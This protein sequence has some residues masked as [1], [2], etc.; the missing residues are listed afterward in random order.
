MPI[1]FLESKLLKKRI[2]STNIS[3]AHDILTSNDCILKDDV[4]APD[5]IIKFVKSLKNIENI[6]GV[7]DAEEWNRKGLKEF[8]GLLYEN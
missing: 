1:V 4:S 8:E 7:K 5:Q 6:H 3:S 2:I